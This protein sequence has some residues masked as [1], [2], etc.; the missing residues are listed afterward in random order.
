M[1]HLQKRIE[2]LEEDKNKKLV[3]I[4]KLTHELAE[5][6]GALLTKSEEMEN[7]K[8]LVQTLSE[9]LGNNQGHLNSHNSAQSRR[10]PKKDGSDSKVCVLL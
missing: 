9:E 1:V 4:V 7:T 10:K 6:R 5:T 2:Y 8:A 3:D